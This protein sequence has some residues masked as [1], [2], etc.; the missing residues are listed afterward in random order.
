MNT[1][2]SQERLLHISDQIAE[3]ITKTHEMEVVHKELIGRVHPLY[4]K[5]A[6]N[7]VHY[8]ALR[9]FDIEKLQ[10]R[11]KYLGLPGVDSAEAH[12]MSTLR[13]IQNIVNHLRGIPDAAQPAAS[14]SVKKSEKLLRINTR[15]LF[16]F[17]SKNRWTRIMV[18]LP[19][20][21]AEDYGMINRLIRKGMNSARINCAHDNPEVWG[22]MIAHIQQT[23]KASKKNCKI[24]MDL[25]G[26]KIR[27][28]MMKPGPEIL[29]FKPHRDLSGNVIKPARLWIAPPTVLPPDDTADAI[30][31]VEPALV[32]KLKRGNIIHFTD[33]RGKKNSFVIERKQG[34]GKWGLCNDSAYLKTGTE[35]IFSKVKET[36]KEV[37]LV[38]TLLP[39]E[40]FIFLHTG[41]LLILHQDPMPGEPAQYNEHGKLTAHAHISCTLPEI[42]NDVIAGEAVFFDDGEIEGVIETKEED[43]LYI[44]ILHAKNSGSKLRAGKG[45]NFPD[46]DLKVSGLT[47]KDKEDLDF[48]A[49]WA[50]VVNLSFVNQAS[51]VETYL[52]E[53][54]KKE[55]K[56]GLIL[57]IETRKG[58]INLPE[59][60]LH[61]MQIFP[62]G[63]MIARGDLAVETGWK[64]FASIQEE[65]M[66]VGEAAHVPAVWATQVL[67]RMAKSGVPTRSEITDAALAQRAECV[68]LNKGEYIE[69]TVEVLDSILRKMQKNHYKS[70]VQLPKLKDVENLKL[71]I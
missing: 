12:V 66:R 45:I 24:M 44:R 2:K 49:Q 71:S 59:I 15:K 35:L 47:E 70:I 20:E 54:A 62:V 55:K 26:P 57:K 69:K 21:A 10:S 34:G 6:L 40:Q 58:F 39:L 50:D 17:Q 11:L 13:S 38:G 64:D 19:T 4:R 60:L 8:L 67:E 48:V 3:I 25:A 51:D 53:I 65:I 61:A 36:G 37:D 9:S 46:S 7:L 52:E 30:I 32:K 31:P 14:I 28:G 41:D 63:I 18:T 1:I 16:G 22:K 42:F 5:S 68:M 27:T 29:R 23:N 33:A 56:P 43:K